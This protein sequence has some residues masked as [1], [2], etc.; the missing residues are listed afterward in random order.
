MI[1]LNEF[2][3]G[4]SQDRVVINKNDKNLRSMEIE[5]TLP[6]S[7]ISSVTSNK[8]IKRWQILR[9]FEL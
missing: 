6:E 9:I 5:R 2:T 7:S 8:A 3:T 1:H 4:K